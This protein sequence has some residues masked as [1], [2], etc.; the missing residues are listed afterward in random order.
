MTQ[1]WLNN[2]EILYKNYDI[3]P[4]DNK[5]LNE[6]LNAVTRFGIFTLILIIIADGTDSNKLYI[7]FFIIGSTILIHIMDEQ[8]RNNTKETFEQYKTVPKDDRVEYIVTK[9]KDGNQIK[10]VTTGEIQT[11]DKTRRIP[12]GTSHEPDLDLIEN[13][14]EQQKCRAP[15]K[16]NPYMNV[17]YSDYYD[18]TIENREILP[19]CTNQVLS[20]EEVEANDY[21]N[22][23]LEKFT[24]NLYYDIGD[25]FQKHNGNRIFYTLPVTTIP[26]DQ[27][28]F[29]NWLYKTKS[30]CKED[31]NCLPYQDYK[32]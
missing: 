26:N 8:I 14:K 30:N 16:N 20:D 6:K 17:T 1:F 9:A 7:P 12:L 13:R 32:L 3:I 11:Y 4:S 19:A 10:V 22:D 31:N 5:S 24:S 27:I 28:G 15:K 25:L 23:S 29:A 18:A 2:F 21:E